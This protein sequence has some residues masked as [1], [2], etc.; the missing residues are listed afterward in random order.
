MIKINL[1]PQTSRGKVSNTTKQVV[2]IGIAFLVALGVVLG[3]NFWLGGNLTELKKQRTS[4]RKLDKKLESRV[5]K[6]KELEKDVEAL[7]DKIKAIRKIR[8]KQGLPV[9]YIEE[10]VR[11]LPASRIWF[12]SF[13]LNR[14]G[15]IEISGVAM[16][17]QSFAQYVARL[18]K[19]DYIRDVI[20][21]QTSRRTIQGYDLVGFDCEV[22]AQPATEVS[23]EKGGA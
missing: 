11:V 20:T 6:V 22:L 10:I 14:S 12:K 9:S 18:R 23:K 3:A 7:K 16:D 5:K 8:E 15:E 17:N 2:L 13:R 1:L 19:A 4:L 21:K